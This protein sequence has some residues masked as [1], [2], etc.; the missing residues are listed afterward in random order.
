[1]T[2]TKWDMISTEEQESLKKTRLSNTNCTGCGKP[3]PTEAAFAQHFILYNQ[4]YLNIGY[5]PAKGPGNK[6][7]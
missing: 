7:F 1:M 4:Q 6:T 3:L 2:V 5:C